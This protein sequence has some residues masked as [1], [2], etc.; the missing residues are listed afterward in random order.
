M[1]EVY[2]AG[3]TDPVVQ[4]SVDCVLELCLE[5]SNY[6]IEYLNSSLLIAGTNAITEEQ[7][8]TV[9]SLVVSFEAQ[10]GDE[11]QVL[12]EVLEESWNRADA[13]ADD[14][15]IN[16]RQILLDIGKPVLIG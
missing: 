11:L 14:E 9:R 5:A 2:E 16:W 8:A 10:C 4:S 15:A 1:E 13:G 3:R 12:L 7:R 6:K